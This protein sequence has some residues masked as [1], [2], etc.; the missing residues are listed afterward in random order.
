MQLIRDSQRSLGTID[1]SHSVPVMKEKEMWTE[2]RFCV[3]VY[4]TF[5]ST[6]KLNTLPWILVHTKVVN[7]NVFCSSLVQFLFLPHIFF[8][9]QLESAD[10][11]GSLRRNMSGMSLWT[12]KKKKC[13]MT[14][15]PKEYRLTRLPQV[16]TSF[17]LSSFH[18][19]PAS[20]SVHLLCY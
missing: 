19:S 1:V 3:D 10:E 15:E 7:A 2:P 17:C 5:C 8:G 11:D 12:K 20:V 9:D 13:L 16:L 14:K 4:S 18:P 6:L